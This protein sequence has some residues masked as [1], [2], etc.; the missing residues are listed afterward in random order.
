MLFIKTK[1]KDILVLQV[2]VDDV[3]FGATN[4]SLCKEFS[5]IMCKEFE[6]SMMGDLTFFLGQ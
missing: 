5:E 1:G 6:M 3:L 4:N 2:Y